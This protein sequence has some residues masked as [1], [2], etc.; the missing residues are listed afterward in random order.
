MAGGSAIA[1]LATSKPT[2][3]A[4][5]EARPGLGPRFPDWRWRSSMRLSLARVLEQQ[6]R[7][8]AELDVVVETTGLVLARVEHVVPHLPAH[9]GALGEEQRGA[10]AEVE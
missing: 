6:Q 2:T 4:R 5:D 9:A 8:E 10:G 7:T 1:S 3:R